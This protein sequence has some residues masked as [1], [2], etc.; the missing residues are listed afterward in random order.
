MSFEKILQVISD[1]NN[2]GVI[3]SIESDNKNQNKTTYKIKTNEGIEIASKVDEPDHKSVRK[4]MNRG[5]LLFYV[6]FK[7]GKAYLDIENFSR[8]LGIE[9]TEF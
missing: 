2:E 6:T 4:E 3:F 8:I 7:G 1:S 5:R 9:N